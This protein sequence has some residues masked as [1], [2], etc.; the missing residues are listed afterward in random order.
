MGGSAAE[1]V[2]ARVNNISPDSPRPWLSGDRLEA[3]MRVS[4][5]E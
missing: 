3:F 1:T 2:S 5:N 4:M